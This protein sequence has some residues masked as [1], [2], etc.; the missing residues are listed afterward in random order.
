MFSVLKPSSFS[1]VVPGAE[2][3]KRSRPSTSPSL[4]THFHQLML[5]P[6]STAR[7]AVLTR[8]STCSRYC[9]LCASKSS[10]QGIETTRTRGPSAAIAFA[11]ASVEPTSA[12]VAIRISSGAPSPVL[13]SHSTY[14]PCSSPS[15]G[16][17]SE[18]SSVST[19]WRESSRATGPSSRS[20]ATFQA[21]EVSLASAGRM[22]HRRG[23]ARR[24]ARAEGHGVVRPDPHHRQAHQRGQP[25]RAAHVVGEDQE[26]RAIGL[27]DPSVSGRAVD[28]RA[29]RVLA[30][31][32]GDV[33]PGVH[34]GELAAALEDRLGRLDQVRGAADHRG[35][36]LGEGAHR[37]LPGGA[38]GD[39]LARRERGQRL[40]PAIAQAS[41]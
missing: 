10:M 16:A 32:E 40:A 13:E 24:A 25:Y 38:G 9:S 34:L 21:M 4:P 11:A 1:T 8:G 41:A 7:R 37:L 33:A 30:D 20:S 26:G 27:D 39:A 35:R 6:G 2:A 22:T 23:I 18:R 15:A 36:E 3:P 12:P 19:F 14:P 31:A 29:H 5:A 17:V 28:D